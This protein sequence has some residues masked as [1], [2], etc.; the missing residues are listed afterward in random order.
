MGKAQVSDVDGRI[1]QGP[2]LAFRGGKIYLRSCE[3]PDFGG[4]PVN[5]TQGHRIPGPVPPYHRIVPVGDVPSSV[6]SHGDI[7]WSKPF[8]FI[9]SFVIAFGILHL[10]VGYGSD[11]V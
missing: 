9:I 10:I 3:L 6:G 2:D 4:D 11:E 1:E 7:A 5:P 8:V